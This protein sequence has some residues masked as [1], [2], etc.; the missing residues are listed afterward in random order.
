MKKNLKLTD[1]SKDG[2]TQLTEVNIDELIPLPPP[3]D[4][5]EELPGLKTTY[6]RPERKTGMQS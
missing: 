3:Y 6:R 4:K 2:D 1:F 5:V